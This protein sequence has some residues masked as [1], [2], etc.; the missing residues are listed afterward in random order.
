LILQPLS[1]SAIKKVLEIG[2]MASIKIK[3]LPHR[4]GLSQR[5]S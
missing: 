2:R 4:F 5:S 1:L 3:G